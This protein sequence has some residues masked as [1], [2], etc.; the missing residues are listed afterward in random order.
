MGGP[1]SGNRAYGLGYSKGH[2]AGLAEGLSARQAKSS[3]LGRVAVAIGVATVL[4]QVGREVTPGLAAAIQKRRARR[5]E[6]PG[7][8]SASTETDATGTADQP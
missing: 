1:G 5:R 7:Q 3:G 2:A 4:V 8:G 6:Q